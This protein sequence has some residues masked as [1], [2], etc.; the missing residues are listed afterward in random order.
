[1][2]EPPPADAAVGGAE[3][4]GVRGG[5]GGRAG[6]SGRTAAQRVGRRN[7]SPDEV[8]H[9]LEIVEEILPIS[10]AEWELVERRHFAYHSDMQRSSDHLRKKFNELARTRIP[11]GDPN[12]PPG[13][14]GAKR[15]RTLI[16]EKTEAGTGSVSDGFGLYLGPGDSD[17]D[18][19]ALGAVDGEGDDNEG[20]AENGAVGDRNS[21][22]GVVAVPGQVSVAGSVPRGRTAPTPVTNRRNRPRLNND[23]PSFNEVFMMMITQQ[24]NDRLAEQEERRERQRQVDLQMQM[25][26]NF[27]SGMM[28]MMMQASG[29]QLPAMN[30]MPAMNVM[31]T[32]ATPQAQV[33]RTTMN[34]TVAAPHEQD[35]GVT[36]AEQQSID[37]EMMPEDDDVSGGN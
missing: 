25:Q 13:V 19:D 22:V 24:Q 4:Q 30:N 34:D 32:V 33:R 20:S 11:T 21:A 23:E 2:A 36:D 5:R 29:L 1:M 14:S 17:D 16:I 10:G 12:I 35:L 15:I 18:D 6:R 26:Q 9:L 27:M 3:R 37:N 28:L 31:N 7:Y 8:A